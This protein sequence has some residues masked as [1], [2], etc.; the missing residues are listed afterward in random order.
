MTTDSDWGG[1]LA[2]DSAAATAE[3]VAVPEQ[4]VASVQTH[5]DK[6]AADEDWADW[7]GGNSGDWARSADTY[8]QDAA[9]SAAAGFDASAEASLAAAERGYA[10]AADEAAKAGDYA[11]AADYNIDAAAAEVSLYDS[12]AAAFDADAGLDS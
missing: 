4:V 9:D 2:D 7:H 1:Y 10:L 8:V 6:A 11:A 3:P 5:L 12:T